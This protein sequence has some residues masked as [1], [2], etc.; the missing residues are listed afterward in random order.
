MAFPMDHV[1]EVDGI[2]NNFGDGYEQRLNTGLPR[3][4]A[5]GEGGVTSYIGVNVFTVNV[6]RL[7]WLTNPVSGNA[8]LDNS[9]KVLW[10]FFKDRFYDV[11]NNVPQWE[12]FYWY[13]PI[14]NDDTD[15]WTGD[16][17][18]SGTNS[19]G[20]AV[21]EKTGRYLVRFTQ[22]MS[23]TQFVY[24]LFRFGLELREVPA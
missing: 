17:T 4:R 14:E 20:E 13:N 7:Q 16:T 11:T 19:R 18:S 21:T 9:T 2:I 3:S 10:K 15:T 1:L 5:D 12:S 23:R 8:N 24:C 6:P 22:R